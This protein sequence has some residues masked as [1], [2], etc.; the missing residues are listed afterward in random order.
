MLHKLKF[1][2]VAINV[3]LLTVVLIAVFAAAYFLL[4][5]QL[6]DQERA[7]LKK[8]VSTE[9][10]KPLE[11]LNTVDF[12]DSA[13]ESGDNENDGD[14]ITTH[15]K[16]VWSSKRS[17]KAANVEFIEDVY[18]EILEEENSGAIKV[19]YYESLSD[20]KQMEI[21]LMMRDYIIKNGWLKSDSLKARFFKEKFPQSLEL[22]QIS[23]K[24]T[25]GSL[26]ETVSPIVTKNTAFVK[27][28]CLIL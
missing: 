1:K 27:D 22:A 26:R 9:I 28:K 11:S 4:E 7:L 25:S 23:L 18:S 21:I 2:L 15:T 10:V 12:P 3:V 19:V 5:S 16:G 13:P 14:I 20:E 6:I 24:V 17:I 8:V